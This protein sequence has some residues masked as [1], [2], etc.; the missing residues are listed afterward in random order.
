VARQLFVSERYYNTIAVIDLFVVGN[1]SDQVFGFASAS[2]IGSSALNLPVDLTPV[3]RD[4]ENVN[5][6]SNPTLDQGSDFYVANQG[7]TTRSF[8]CSKTAPS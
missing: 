2:R 6:A 1:S 8:A 3:H 5:W 4:M 7:E